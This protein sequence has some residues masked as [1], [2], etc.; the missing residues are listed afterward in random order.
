MEI[1]LYLRGNGAL[2]AR[3]AN[4]GAPPAHPMKHLGRCRLPAESLSRGFVEALARDGST[5]ASGS[6]RT[7]LRTVGHAIAYRKVHVPGASLVETAIELACRAS[8]A[9]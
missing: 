1:E 8:S 7:L 4:A 9:A 6:D 2:V 5:I 3:A